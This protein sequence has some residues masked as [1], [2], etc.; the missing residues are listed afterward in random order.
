MPL[1]M[2]HQCTVEP[3]S[4]KSFELLVDWKLCCF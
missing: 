1:T 2:V 4:M 3:G